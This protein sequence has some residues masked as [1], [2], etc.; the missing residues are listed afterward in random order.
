MGM[1]ATTRPLP[2]YFSTFHTVSVECVGTDFSTFRPELIARF[3]RVAY[4]S[5][6]L[7]RL[8]DV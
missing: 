2:R 4:L 1:D 8:F 3:V 5:G 7:P 6:E